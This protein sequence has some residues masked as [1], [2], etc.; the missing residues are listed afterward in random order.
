MTSRFYRTVFVLTALALSALSCSAPEKTAAP[1]PPPPPKPA[2][3]VLEI[4][5]AA[6]AYGFAVATPPAKLRVGQTEPVTVTLRN[7]SASPWP[8]AHLTASEKPL[9][10]SYHWLDAAGKPVVR[11]GKRTPLTADIPAGG[12]VTVVLQVQAPDTPGKFFLQP[13]LVQE[14]VAWFSTK[15]APAEAA[16]PVTVIP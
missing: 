13:D 5:G 1:A 8:A 10:A 11:D 2:P 3:V 6:M 16:L 12:E 15:S 7:T 14:K 9:R 4:P